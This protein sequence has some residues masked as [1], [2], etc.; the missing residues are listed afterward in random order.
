[1]MPILSIAL[2]GLGLMSGVGVIIY[3]SYAG[4]MWSLARPFTYGAAFQW[5]GFVLLM[6]LAS[7]GISYFIPDAWHSMMSIV[8]IHF[9][10][11][12]AFHVFFFKIDEF[13]SSYYH[14]QMSPWILHA[15]IVCMYFILSMN[16]VLLVTIHSPLI[17]RIGHMGIE[18]LTRSA[19]LFSLLLEIKLRRSGVYTSHNQPK[20]EQ[21]EYQNY[22]NQW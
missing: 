9:G 22:D 8:L 10:C 15:S 5:I 12:L 2:Y 21:E 1:M 14:Y 7:G 16:S 6:A 17:V 3:A 18:Y 13:L 4:L 20:K 11:M 19:I